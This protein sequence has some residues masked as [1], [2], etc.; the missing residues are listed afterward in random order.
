VIR[1]GDVSWSATYVF[2]SIPE[3]EKNIVLKLLLLLLLLFA[4]IAAVAVVMKIV[5]PYHILTILSSTPYFC[6]NN[7]NIKRH[8]DKLNF[9][10]CG[11][12][13]VS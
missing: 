10:R 7:T 9:C 2:P 1:Q 5:L 4:F 11:I 8:I 12:F 3:T 6:L 13:S